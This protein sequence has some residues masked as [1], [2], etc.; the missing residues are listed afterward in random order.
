MEAAA[1]SKLGLLK[2]LSIA[3]NFSKFGLQVSKIKFNTQND[4]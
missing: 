1:S 3:G 4:E 2:L